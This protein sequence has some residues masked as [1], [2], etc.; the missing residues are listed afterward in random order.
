M[1]IVTQFHR[2]FPGRTMTFGGI[3]D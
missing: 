2:L 1:E 3:A